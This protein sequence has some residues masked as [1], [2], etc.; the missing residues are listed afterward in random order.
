MS[1]CGSCQA[2]LDRPGPR[3]VGVWEGARSPATPVPPRALGWGFPSLLEPGQVSHFTPGQGTEQMGP[4]QLGVTAQPVA[5]LPG[6]RTDRKNLWEG[7]EHQ[8]PCRRGGGWVG[9]AGGLPQAPGAA[10]A[11]PSLPP[12]RPRSSPRPLCDG[13]G[14]MSQT[15]VSPPPVISRGSF[16]PD[17][18]PSVQICEVEA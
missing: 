16:S 11:L 10:P 6:L 4:G 8:G 9:Q 18:V 17:L 7:C 15:L 13:R 3:P 5:C 12:P 1:V 2:G 14:G